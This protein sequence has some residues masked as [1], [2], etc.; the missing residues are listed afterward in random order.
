MLRRATPPAI[1]KDTLVDQ[2]DLAI[3]ALGEAVPSNKAKLTM[4][5]SL[6]AFS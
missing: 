6:I 1:R 3:R 2:L 4:R 5:K